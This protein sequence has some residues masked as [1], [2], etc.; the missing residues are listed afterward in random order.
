MEIPIK[1]DGKEKFR[2]LVEVLSGQVTPRLI[3][4]CNL[5][6][7]EKDVLALL[8]Y[9]NNE[10]SN[11]PIEYRSTI[12]FGAETKK[13][14]AEDLKGITLDNIYNIMMALK[15]NGFIEGKPEQLKYILPD[16]DYITFKFTS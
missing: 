3:P 13:K 11:I 10:Y 5:R 4:F 14:I 7:R 15:K 6:P 9:Y 2:W 8:Y 12:L 16:T 1:V